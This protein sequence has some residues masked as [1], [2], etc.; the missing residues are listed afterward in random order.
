MK[1]I[2][3]ALIC[4]TYTNIL[5]KY[6]VVLIYHYN[7]LVYNR[8]T[9]ESAKQLLLSNL[10]STN[11]CNDLIVS[12]KIINN[13]LMKEAI[14]SS[15]YINTKHLYAGPTLLL[16][17]NNASPSIVRSLIKWSQ[18]INGLSLL[19][20]KY[21]NYLVDAEELQSMPDINTTYSNFAS[22]IM[23]PTGELIQILSTHQNTLCLT[24]DRHSEQN[25]K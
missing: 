25:T 8:T 5:D 15:I 23:Q 3:K 24:L 21:I 17:C 12:V 6:P 4:N 1:K 20:G 9:V 14:K 19:G 16:Y 2:N 10:Q 11:S 7:S 13:K 18:S 22:D